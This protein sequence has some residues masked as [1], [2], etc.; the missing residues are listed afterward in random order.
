M[1]SR[2]LDDGS[3]T[4]IASSVEASLIRI[5]RGRRTEPSS[6]PTATA[7][8]GGRDLDG[9]PR[10]NFVQLFRGF[11][12]SRSRCRPA[13][14]RWL[15]H[16]DGMDIGLGVRMCDL[17]VL[18]GID[19]DGTGIDGAAWTGAPVDEDGRCSSRP[20]CSTSSPSIGTATGSRSRIHVHAPIVSAVPAVRHRGPER[21]RRPRARRP[22]GGSTPT[23][24]IFEVN[25][26]GS[27]RADGV[28]PIIV[29]A[30]GAPGMN[31][32]ANRAVRFTVGGDEG[33]SGS[34]GCEDAGAG[35]PILRYTWVRGAVDADTDLRV[36]IARL[37]FGDDGVFH[38]EASTDS[39]S[40]G[41][42]SPPISSRRSPPAGGLPPRRLR[43]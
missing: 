15:L 18:H 23:Y 11:A 19:W 32:D 41:P 20:A 21:R 36:D 28:Y 31:L 3:E 27:E 16:P 40:R 2:S 17:E 9:Y 14:S 30:P 26:P 29:V 34:I 4:L 25:R 33:F 42:R 38:I 8:S 22:R 6:S 24:S 43:R 7:L 13:A 12:P 1:W 5:S 37:S 35:A 10:D 39:T